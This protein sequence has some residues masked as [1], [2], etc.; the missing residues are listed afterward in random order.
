MSISAA[1]RLIVKAFGY[2]KDFKPA[3]T[4][5]KAAEIATNLSKGIKD[6]DRV[7]GSML[8]VKTNN[9]YVFTL[10]CIPGRGSTGRRWISL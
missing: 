6:G 8:P 5:K 1:L 4:M 2:I 3:K 10:G 7:Y 9:T